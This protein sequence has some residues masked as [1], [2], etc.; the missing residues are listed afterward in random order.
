M[1]Q[2]TPEDG[3]YYEYDY[4]DEDVEVA[5]SA[6]TIAKPE[7]T[8]FLTTAATMTTTTTA[9]TTTEW[10][11]TTTAITVTTTTMS[12]RT[13]TVFAEVERGEEKEGKMTD[14]SVAISDTAVSEVTEREKDGETDKE[15][16]RT[17]W[18]SPETLNAETEFKA[19]L[20]IVKTEDTHDCCSLVMRFERI[21]L[22]LVLLMSLLLNFYLV[23]VYPFLFFMGRKWLRRMIAKSG[24]EEEDGAKKRRVKGRKMEEGKN[25][26]WFFEPQI[27]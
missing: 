22:E 16:G 4:Q 17:E 13:T 18:I 19:P 1:V 14:A 27:L 24:K 26:F 23:L 20:K 10:I 12:A 9:I 11:S 21:A 3:E 15:R 5:T 6:T 25:D 8:T 2:N 7:K